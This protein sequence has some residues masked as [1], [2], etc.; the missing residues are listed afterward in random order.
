MC[1]ACPLPSPRSGQGAS[2]H[3]G[4]YGPVIS[5]LRRCGG[6]CSVDSKMVEFRI[7][8]PLA[9]ISDG[10]AVE[11]Q[12]SKERAT[13][14]ILLLHAGQVVSTDTL[15]DALWP[16][17]PPATARNSLQVR[18]AALRKALGADRIESRPP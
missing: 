7:L 2:M 5:N 12:G 6:C 3:R 13:L 4:V 11:I 10:H 18:I 15:I 1:G 8:G 16:D 14:A 17:E 9:V